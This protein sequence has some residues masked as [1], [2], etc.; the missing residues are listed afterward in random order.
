MANEEA[1]I[2]V[3][4]KEAK[5]KA[6][7]RKFSQNWDLCI[8]LKGVDL[9]KPENRLNLEFQLPEGR[10]RDTGVVVIADSLAAAATGI[11][12][13]VIRKDEID[14]LSK[15]QKKLKIIMAQ[16]DWFFG[17]MGLMPMIGKTL[18]LVLGPKGKMPKPLPP[19]ANVKAFVEAAKKNTR[20]KLA[21]TPV[22]HISVGTDKL[23][24]QQIANNISA[25]LNFVKEKL[26]KGKNSIH[27]AYI[28]LTMGPAIKLPLKL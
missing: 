7:P 11:A 16:N 13:V 14:K 5:E 6:N 20:I 25:V 8:N 21:T 12:S 28:K 24:E 10:G 3:K 2:L 17:E 22:L 23:T 4:V 15:D 19:T 9:K 18:G 27:S 1:D 26:P